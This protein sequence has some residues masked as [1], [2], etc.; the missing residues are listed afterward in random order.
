[1]PAPLLASARVREAGL[2]GSGHR[3]V[4]I[5]TSRRISSRV[6]QPTV[7]DH[8]VERFVELTCVDQSKPRR[9]ETADLWLEGT[10]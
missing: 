3:L 1:M 10:G 2:L 8:L 7:S 5:S 6:A 9:L 4:G